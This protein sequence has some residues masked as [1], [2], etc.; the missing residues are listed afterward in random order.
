MLCK[1]HPPVFSCFHFKLL[2]KWWCQDEYCYRLQLKHNLSSEIETSSYLAI[3]S[4]SLT[5]SRSLWALHWKN[6]PLPHWLL[7]SSSSS[8]G[9]AKHHLFQNRAQLCVFM[10]KLTDVVKTKRAG[11][12]QYRGQFSKLS[13]WQCGNPH[14]VC[15]S[16]G[17]SVTD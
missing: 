11:P 13:T 3:S 14:R 10:R 2:S 5:L 1:R 17:V 15:S 8:S 6:K 12:H 7:S 16:G 9:P 4:N